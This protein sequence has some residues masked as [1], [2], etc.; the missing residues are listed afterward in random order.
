[1][2]QTTVSTDHCTIVM[3]RAAFNAIP[4]FTPAPDEPAAPVMLHTIDATGGITSTPMYEGWVYEL[5][6]IGWLWADY[7]RF[8]MS[9]N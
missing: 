1:M 2:E 3:N 4:V 8:P 9:I 5:T 6:Q 7:D